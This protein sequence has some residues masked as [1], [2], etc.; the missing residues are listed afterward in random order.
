[1]RVIF[2]F[3]R[4]FFARPAYA[5]ARVRPTPRHQ[6]DQPQHRHHHEGNRGE[7]AAG[8]HVSS[9]GRPPGRDGRTC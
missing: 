9:A 5:Y 7:D 4:R 1:M 3:I 6:C 8:E 2:E